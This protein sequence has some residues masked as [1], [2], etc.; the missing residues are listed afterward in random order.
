MAL[1]VNF[2]SA[3]ETARA[4]AQAPAS[5]IIYKEA[6]Y[7]IARDGR[8]GEI[9]FKG[10]DASAV[11]QSAIDALPAE[12]G[13]ISLK[14]GIYVLNTK[15]TIPRND[16]ILEGS[17]Y[18]TVLRDNVVD[19]HLIA[20][21]GPTGAQLKE[22][23][24]KDLKIECVV[25]KTAGNEIDILNLFIGGIIR[26]F[27]EG[28]AKALN[29]VYITGGNHLRIYDV[30]IY[31]MKQNSVV[32]DGRNDVYFYSLIT[33]NSKNP[34]QAVGIEVLSSWGSLY[35]INSDIIRA[36]Y[37]L[38]FACKGNVIWTWVIN[39]AFD[40]CTVGIRFPSPVT[41]GMYT[42][43]CYFLGC[44]SSTSEDANVLLAS[45][46][47]VSDVKFV[48]CRFYNAFRSGVVIENVDVSTS[49]EF[50]GCTIA[51]NSREADGAHHG[52]FINYAVTRIHFYR[53]IIRN[54]AKLG[55]GVQGYGVFANVA[56]VD[57]D[58]IEN[59]LRY[60]ATGAIGGYANII[61][62][63]KRNKGFVTEN[64]GV[65]TFTAGAT[66]VTIS[67][68]LATT[69]KIVLVTPQHS[70]IVDIRVIAKTAT[71]FTVE[72][73]TAPTANRTFDWYAEV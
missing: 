30:S 16:V 36:R 9:K 22:V 35:I 64:S 4:L 42:A 57:V 39:T 68:G 15:I 52:V 12:G 59:D 44:W 53:N 3:L 46:S 29:G 61:G 19:D 26:V 28:D 8:T 5:F 20:V 62:V 10:K 38:N 55:T 1:R 65:A 58:I 14:E 45:G 71:D 31:N 56:N 50:I 54:D 67:H 69:P 33:D 70:E 43:G 6:E 34:R 18:S 73:T 49:V 17:G 66:S 37:G 60:N 13:R 24:V 21:R 48:N 41:A 51:S 32:F 27:I 25:A 11:I 40:N 7:Y 2:D 23:W 47:I 63:V 72:V